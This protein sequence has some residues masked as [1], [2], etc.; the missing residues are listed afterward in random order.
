MINMRQNAQ[1]PGVGRVS[2]QSNNLIQSGESH[3][4]HLKQITTLNMQPVASIKRA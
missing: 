2:L 3:G 1:V 4:E